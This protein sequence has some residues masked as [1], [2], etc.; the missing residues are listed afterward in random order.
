MQLYYPNRSPHSTIKRGGAAH[1]K[2]PESTIID[3]LDLYPPLSE[4][5]SRD[6]IC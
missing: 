6:L 1:Y 3:W 2:K 5:Q 4:A